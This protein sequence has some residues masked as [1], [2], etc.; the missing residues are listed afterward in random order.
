[1]CS[2]QRTQRYLLCLLC[3]PSCPTTCTALTHN[4]TEGVRNMVNMPTCLVSFVLHYLC[5]LNIESSISQHRLDP[6]CCLQ[7]SKWGAMYL[8]QSRND[9]IQTSISSFRTIYSCGNLKACTEF[10]CGVLAE[11]PQPSPAYESFLMQSMIYLNDSQLCNSY[12][13]ETGMGQSYDT[14]TPQVHIRLIAVIALDCNTPTTRC[15]SRSWLSS[16]H[17]V[18]QLWC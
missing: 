1:M 5:N 2:A 4:A 17:T 11:Q 18:L 12:K 6:K 8:Q 16:W 14:E 3:C 15:S 10:F 7:L 9:F 13:G